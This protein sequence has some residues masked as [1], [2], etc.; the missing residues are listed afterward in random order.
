M[1]YLTY[2]WR[3]GKKHGPYGMSGRKYL[4][5]VTVEDDLV[6]SKIDGSCLGQLTRRAEIPKET[7]KVSES[8]F[9]DIKAAIRSLFCIP[10]LTHQ[11]IDDIKFELRSQFSGEAVEEAI[12]D[13]ERKGILKRVS[14]GN[15]RMVV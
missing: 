4:G 13:L 7:A 12:L 6:Y 3:N 5:P 9:I 10:L 1:V 8:R 2:R 14:L 15:Y 11:N